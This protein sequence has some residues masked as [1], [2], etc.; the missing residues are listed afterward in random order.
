MQNI[1]RIC[2][3]KSPATLGRA[4]QIK[5]TPQYDTSTNHIRNTKKRNTTT[6]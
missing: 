6:Y 3:K 1:M 5:N 2:H 4:Y